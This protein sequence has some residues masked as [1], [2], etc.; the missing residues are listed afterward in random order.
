MILSDTYIWQ[1]QGVT[2][3]EVQA[4]M[5]GH[6]IK[7]FPNEDIAMYQ[8]KTKTLTIA[9]EGFAPGETVFRFGN[10]IKENSSYTAEVTSV[11]ASLTLT[12]GSKWKMVRGA[13][14]SFLVYFVF[15]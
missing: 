8:S 2:I 11:S 1:L 13:W 14:R 7:V 9:G 10:A 15:I 6:G 5:S 4:D 3:S 12:E